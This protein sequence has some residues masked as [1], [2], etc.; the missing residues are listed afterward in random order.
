MQG[1]KG[2]KTCSFVPSGLVAPVASG[3]DQFVLAGHR[4][5]NSLQKGLWMDSNL[6]LWLVLILLLVFCFGPMLFMSRRGKDMKKHEAPG[7]R[8]GSDK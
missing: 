6:W 3:A 2:P 5:A 1:P 4:A 7:K 8:P